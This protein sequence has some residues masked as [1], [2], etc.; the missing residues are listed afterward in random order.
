MSDDISNA[1]VNFANSAGRPYYAIA[2]AIPYWREDRHTAISEAA[3]FHAERRGL[4]PGHEPDDWLAAEAEI[5]ERPNRDVA[6]GA[7]CS[8]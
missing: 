4:A 8:V 7:G 6:V 2:T 5:E 1:A 3:C